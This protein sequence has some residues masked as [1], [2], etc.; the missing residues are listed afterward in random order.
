M[1]IEQKGASF[2]GYLDGKLY[3]EYQDSRLNKTGGV[4]VWTKADAQTS[5]DNLKIE[6]STKV[7]KEIKK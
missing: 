6:T 2:K 3:L 5:F 7:K 1:S 4:G